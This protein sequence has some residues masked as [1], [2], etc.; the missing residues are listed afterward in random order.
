MAIPDEVLDAAPGEF[1]MEEESF[2]YA[3]A[4]EMPPFPADEDRAAPPRTFKGKGK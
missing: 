4:E 2:H 1:R 3:L